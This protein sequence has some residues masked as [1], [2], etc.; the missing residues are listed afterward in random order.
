MDSPL[1]TQIG[2]LPSTTWWLSNY[3]LAFSVPNPCLAH[4]IFMPLCPSWHEEVLACHFEMTT[5]QLRKEMRTLCDRNA[6]GG[7]DWILSTPSWQG[8]KGQKKK[9]KTFYLH[10]IG[11]VAPA[12]QVQVLRDA[13]GHN[14][15]SKDP[16]GQR[17]RRTHW[18]AY[19]CGDPLS[20]KALAYR[21]RECSRLVESWGHLP[22]PGPIRTHDGSM[23]LPSQL[24]KHLKVLFL[25]SI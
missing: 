4:P 10:P 11:G 1:L 13:C 24:R 19:F 6:L 12:V 16:G 8:H 23:I 9:R 5:K 25:I 18:E 7:W 17:F 14:P 22:W 15:D 2:D 21:D 3:P 20:T